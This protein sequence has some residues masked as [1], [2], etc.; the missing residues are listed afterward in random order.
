MLPGIGLLWNTT[1]DIFIFDQECLM[2]IHVVKASDIKL[3]D[4]NVGARHEAF[5]CQDIP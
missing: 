4:C 3:C 1:L 2:K 5:H